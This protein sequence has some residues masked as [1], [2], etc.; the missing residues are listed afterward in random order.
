MERVE[1][2]PRR[3]L[4]ACGCGQVVDDAHTV[5]G[6]VGVQLRILTAEGLV[7]VDENLLLPLAK[8]LVSEDRG[9]QL[10]VALAGFEDARADVKLL[11]GDP[12]SLGDLLQ[13]VRAW[14]AKTSL[15]LREVR[16]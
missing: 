14:L 8:T 2:I 13:D 15:D 1:P 16:V 11:R 10:R 3:E 5:I 4:L 9:D 6:A 7:N 12:Q